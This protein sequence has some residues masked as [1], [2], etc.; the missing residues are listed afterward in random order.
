MT[1]DILAVVVDDFSSYHGIILHWLFAA[2]YFDYFLT[3]LFRL[4]SL[5]VVEVLNR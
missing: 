3:P 5:L 1:G 4:L 2:F